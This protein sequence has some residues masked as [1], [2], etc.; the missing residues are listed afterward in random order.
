MALFFI[1]L[2]PAF[3][4]AQR[5]ISFDKEPL[6]IVQQSGQ[7]IELQ[8]EVATTPEQR[9]RGLMFRTKMAEN[10]GMLF[11]FGKAQPVQ[12]W[13]ENTVLPLDM[14]FMDAAGTVRN[15]K[16]NAVPYSRDIIDSGGAVRYVLELN[17]GS[18][19]KMSI[20]IGDRIASAAT[21]AR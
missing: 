6:T 21:K 18:V 12:M 19:K 5:A 2:M 9:E 8:V 15:I 13:M 14:L 17:A 7:K 20:K 11:D 10:A 16:E 3:S 4:L 1:V